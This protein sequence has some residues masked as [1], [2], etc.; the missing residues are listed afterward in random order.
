MSLRILIV[1]DSSATRFM[2]RDVI[3]LSGHQVVD[4]AETVDAAIKA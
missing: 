3:E 1:D 2:L 4:E